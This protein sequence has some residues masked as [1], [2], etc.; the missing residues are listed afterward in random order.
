MKDTTRGMRS[1]L[2]DR[3]D[4][5]SNGGLGDV[6]MEEGEVD[7]R[8]LESGEVETK[9]RPF[10]QSTTDNKAS[11]ASR[12]QT[13]ESTPA[14]RSSLPLVAQPTSR[15]RTEVESELAPKDDVPANN[16]EPSRL[17]ASP[18]RSPHEAKGSSAAVLSPAPVKRSIIKKSFK[19]DISSSAESHV[20]A[21]SSISDLIPV[22]NKP[23]PSDPLPPT[24]NELVPASPKREEPQTPDSPKPSTSINL[25]PAPSPSGKASGKPIIRPPQAGNRLFGALS[26]IGLKKKAP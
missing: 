4:G 22:D 17:P 19:Y 3:Q 18:V 7:T 25:K 14:V 23:P 26:S 24:E 10:I 11:L 20:F 5:P 12:I 1:W 13:D 2:E 15:P 21:A 8:S 16:G 6:E 9:P